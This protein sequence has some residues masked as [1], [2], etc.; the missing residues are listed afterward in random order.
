MA[1]RVRPTPLAAKQIR[2]ES[3]WWRTNRPFAPALFRDEVRRAF[4]L[5]AEHPEIGAAAEDTEIAGVRRVLL[6]ATRHYL[7]YF[8][9]EADG[10]IDVLAIWSTSRGDGPGL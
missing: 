10:T 6:A 7:Y 3:R 8:V 5:V 1:L 2:R 9:N 4:E